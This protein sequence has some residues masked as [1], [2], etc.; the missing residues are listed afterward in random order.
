MRT[1]PTRLEATFSPARFALWSALLAV[2]LLLPFPANPANAAQGAGPLGPEGGTLSV[3]AAVPLAAETRLLVGHP[4]LAGLLVSTDPEAAGW[5]RGAGL[6]APVQKIVRVP[7][8][9]AASRT[10]YASAAERLYRS[11][12]GGRSFTATAQPFGPVHDFTLTPSDPNTVYAL[13]EASVGPSGPEPFVV[14]SRDG[15]ATWQTA[16][17]LVQGTV[18]AADPG[19]PSVVYL[20]GNGVIYR[21]GSATVLLSVPVDVKSLLVDP[22]GSTT[23]YAGGP[24]GL[25]KSVDRGVTWSFLGGLDFQAGES[26]DRLVADPPLPVPGRPTTLYAVLN[27]VFPVGAPMPCPP[28]RARIAKSTD[29]GATWT[30]ASPPAAH[31]SDLTVDPRL[32]DHLYA[33]TDDGFLLSTDG[34]ATF[35]R[36]NGGILARSIAAVAIDPLPVNGPAKLFAADNTSGFSRGLFTSADRG[37]T[38]VLSARCFPDVRRLV[39]DPRTRGTLYAVTT[40][41]LFAT[42]DGGG[43]WSGISPGTP[44][45]PAPGG[46][47]LDVAIDPR[48]SA[49]LYAVARF[50]LPGDPQ[51]G[52]AFLQSKD[53]GASWSSLSRDLDPHQALTAV[54]VDPSRSGVVFACGGRQAFRLFGARFVAISDLPPTSDSD[55]C[56]RL[57]VTPG[58]RDLYL[59]S[60]FDLSPQ[61]DTF[62][63][64]H[65]HGEHWQYVPDPQVQGRTNDLVSGLDPAT[66]YAATG[67]G[68]FVTHDGA[69]SFKPFALPADS[70]ELDARSGTLAVGTGGGL[71]LLRVGGR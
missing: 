5:T 22:G 32:P 61:F 26:V 9:S 27:P 58:N 11:T 20:G 31:V 44:G 24:Q 35:A 39:P 47:I 4:Y 41:G 13:S 1:Y 49:Q 69:R 12:D 70:L 7:A 37:A 66:L 48:S 38:W 50:A 53:R 28:P 17:D 55:S 29:S 3:V 64:S 33:A 57:I 56:D 68:I 42:R 16:G 30:L 23:L 65:D 8:A 54:A 63:A 2:P 6:P 14:V 62:L 71:F 45:S 51:P 19:D 21:T 34:G 67:T 43:H 46:Q 36:F 59:L 60:S 15:G 40:G 52:Y 10:L 18:L 25:A